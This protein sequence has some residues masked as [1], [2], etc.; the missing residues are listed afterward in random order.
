MTETRPPLADPAA[1]GPILA[2]VARRVQPMMRQMLARWRPAPFDDRMGLAAAYGEFF[3]RLWADPQRLADWQWQYWQ[4]MARLWQ[5]GPPAARNG[6]AEK[7]DR[8][9]RADAWS[10]DPLF[11]FV[12]QSYLLTAERVQ[13][14]TAQTSGLTPE[15]RRK[16]EFF[17]RQWLNAAAPTN[18]LLTNPEALQATLDSGGDNL[19]R[20]FQ[21]LL[22]DIE[23]GG[24]TLKIS[25]TD[26]T[27]FRPGET[28][29]TT[30]GQ[31]IFENDMMQL[32]RYAPA[33]DTVF[34]RPLLLVP[35]W[36]NKYYILDLRPEN[37]LIGWLVAQGHAVFV[38]SWV[39]PGRRHAAKTF[40]DY[41]TDGVVA[42]LDRIAIASGSADCNVAGYC[43]GGTLLAAA[44]AWLQ[45]KGQ[46]G[47]VASATFLTSMIDFAQAGD[48]RLFIDEAQL[49]RLDG[50]MREK[51]I[52]PADFLRETFSL[53]RSNDLIWSFVVNNYLLGREPFPFDL[54]YWNDDATNM[55][56]A[57]HG[58]YL[59]A[60][61]LENRFRQ[62]GGVTLAGVPID[63]GRITTPAY[64]L[65]TREDHI[66]PWRATYDSARLLGGPTTFTLA[67]SG[68]VAGVINPPAS[69]KYDF[70][71]APDLPSD[72]DAWLAGAEKHGGSWWPHWEAWLR[73]FAGDRGAARK[74]NGPAIEAAPGRYVLMQ[75]ET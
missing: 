2:D 50:E 65:S 66:A 41:L 74:P 42:A 70:R 55:P 30:P 71:T 27:A 36:I 26:Y 16:I 20:G 12:K 23:R 51:G 10:A 6:Q 14:L 11:G 24:G 43:L 39:N 13:A 38:I 64:F 34:A 17:N 25:T 73:P 54:L 1:L 47:R 3:G 37:S 59:R 60:C 57:M 33:T 19:V 56:A 29:A 4:D 28:I 18:F 75:G 40:G 58:F 21:H 53:L 63:V 49:A 62:P 5:S 45:A 31:V 61:Y 46:G 9:F 44:L 69:G 15:S 32:I 22:D 68:H 48:M 35:P 52:L 8:R 72:A 7:D 67:A